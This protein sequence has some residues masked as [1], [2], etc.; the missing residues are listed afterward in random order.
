MEQ[1]LYVWDTELTIGAGRYY[2]YHVKTKRPWR[3][4]D[5]KEPEVRVVQP[6]KKAVKDGRA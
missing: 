2:G 5:G 1:E 4:S 3:T 6:T